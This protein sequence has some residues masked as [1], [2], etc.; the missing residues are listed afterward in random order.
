MFS[1]IKS[2]FKTKTYTATVE[3]KMND[4]RIETIKASFNGNA[5][6]GLIEYLMKNLS[7]DVDSFTVIS[8]RHQ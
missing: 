4:G 7:N 6:N 8:I 2:F 3:C 1:K 5:N